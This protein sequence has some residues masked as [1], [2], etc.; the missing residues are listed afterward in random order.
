MKK[1]Y[2]SAG[3]LLT[4]SYALALLIHESGYRPNIIA[5]VWRGGAPIGIAVQELLHYLGV[6]S[7][8]IAIRSAS[9]TGI[10]ERNREVSVHGLEYIVERIQPG[11]SLLIVDDVYDTGL[12]I[13]KIIL[14]LLDR[15]GNNITD[16][17][18]ATPY[19]KPDNNR[20][21]SI[22]DFYLYESDDW[23][24]FPHELSGLTLEEIFSNKIELAPLANRLRQHIITSQANLRQTP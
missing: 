2:I 23:L 7:D 18:V 16:I 6:N 12:S 15:C 21:D 22:P 8:H 14:E 19:F 1:T 13:Q 11:Q 9:Y 10:G 4:D 5:G 24:V 17:K 20:T 3:Q